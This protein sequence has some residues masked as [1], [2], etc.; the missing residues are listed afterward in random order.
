MGI[1]YFRSLRDELLKPE[2]SVPVSH[3]L[4]AAETLD[5]YAV[6]AEIDSKLYDKCS[7]DHPTPDKRLPEKWKSKKNYFSRHPT[8]QTLRRHYRRRFTASIS[9]IL[10]ILPAAAN[11]CPQDTLSFSRIRRAGDV[12]ERSVSKSG[13]IIVPFSKSG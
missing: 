1:C 13:E 10:S 12:V 6:A 7:R 11:R 9:L 8:S 5:S 4:L 3:A 2:H